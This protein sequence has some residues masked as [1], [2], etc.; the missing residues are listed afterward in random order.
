MDGYVDVGI[1]ERETVEIAALPDDSVCYRAETLG[2]AE[3]GLGAGEGVFEIRNVVIGKEFHWQKEE[4]LSFKGCLILRSDG[5]KIQVINRVPV[6]TYLESVVSSEMNANAPIE[7]LKAHAVISRTWLMARIFPQQ[8]YGFGQA[9]EGAGGWKEND[10]ERIVW[11][12]TAQHTGFHVC[13]D[14][15]CQRYQGVTRIMNPDAIA[16][17][18]ATTGMILTYEGKICDARFS[19]CC[20]GTTEVF[21]NCWED[22]SHPYLQGKRDRIGGDKDF[23]DTSDSSVLMMVLNDYDLA[24]KNFYR[25]RQTYTQEEISSIVRRRSGIDFGHILNIIPLER[26]V[27][28]RIVKAK[29]MGTKRSMV[30]GKELEIRKWLSPTHLYSSAFSIKKE[31]ERGGDEPATFIL[32]GRGWG[33]GV[34]L[35]QIGAAMMA[36]KG[37]SYKEILAHYYPGAVLS[38]VQRP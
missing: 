35:C 38:L 5:K 33:H 29:I 10:E 9:A 3:L 19:K 14:D 8:V 17:V 4:T 26:G 13:A 16:A 23:C 18:K 11:Y 7:L 31:N 27:S 6:E 21:E 12:D 20:G 1:L 15:H 32:K 22:V 25:W 36:V 28:G 34:G 2:S 24:T 30:V 37:Y